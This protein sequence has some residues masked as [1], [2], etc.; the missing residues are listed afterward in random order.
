MTDQDEGPQLTPELLD[1]LRMQ[2][3]LDKPI[4]VRYLIW[5]GVW[6]KENKSKVIKIG[7][8]FREVVDDVNV[9]QFEKYRL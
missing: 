9:S 3:G 6:P 1:K 2:Y 8:A 5:L 4:V 7:N